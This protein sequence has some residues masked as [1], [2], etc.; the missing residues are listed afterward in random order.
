MKILVKGRDNPKDE[1][2]ERFNCAHPRCRRR[3]VMMVH[4]AT[5]SGASNDRRCFCL[6]H[7]WS[8]VKRDSDHGRRCYY[9]E[10]IV[11]KASQGCYLYRR[12]LDAHGD[13]RGWQY[14]VMLTPEEAARRKCP[15]PWAQRNAEGRYTLA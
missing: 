11:E 10:R 9:Y 7:A 15:N 2:F 1:G 6:D 12:S 4:D 13:Y 14:A 5:L 8:V 3:A